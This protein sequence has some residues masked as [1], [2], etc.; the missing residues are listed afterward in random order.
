MQSRGFT[1]VELLIVVVIIGILAAVAIPQFT[2]SSTE[3]SMVTAITNARHIV[4]AILRYKLHHNDFPGYPA[5]EA[6]ATEDAL[7][8]Q[9]TLHTDAA[10]KT[11]ATKN[12]AEYP[13]GPYL[14]K[15]P[16]NPINNSNRV[17]IIS[18]SGGTP[19]KQFQ[20]ITTAE[21]IVIDANAFDTEFGWLYCPET[22]ELA[23]NDEKLLGR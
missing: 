19:P 16:L 8:K 5:G 15:F 7:V 18:Q 17:R 20:A 9:L 3:A 12:P 14:R 11:S 6:V 23:P 2:N 13:Y 21:I 1:I 10:G 22:G 4:A